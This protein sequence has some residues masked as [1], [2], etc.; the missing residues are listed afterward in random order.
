MKIG[1]SYFLAFP[2]SNHSLALRVS[3]SCHTAKQSIPSILSTKSIAPWQRC[4]ALRWC[5][6]R[7]GF[8]F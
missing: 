2:T 7:V 3:T 6:I 4:V 8:K 5:G 1:F